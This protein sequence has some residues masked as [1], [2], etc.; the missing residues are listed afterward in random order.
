MDYERTNFSI[1]Q[2][3][4]DETA[5]QRIVMIPSKT[6][7]SNGTTSSPEM[8]PPSRSPLSGG[9]IAGIVIGVVLTILLVLISAFFLIRR[10]RGD[11]TRSIVGPEEL[12]TSFTEFIEEADGRELPSEEVVELPADLTTRHEMAAP[13]T[14]P[15]EMQADQT[16]P[17]EM[18]SEDCL[19]RY[20]LLDTR[21]SKG[22]IDKH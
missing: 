12:P 14:S 9:T 7:A 19:T 17:H 3:V 15:H 22:S 2:C 20:E 18:A 8:P 10:C 11:T 13:P 6:D 16:S 1:A 5:E 4:F 21:R